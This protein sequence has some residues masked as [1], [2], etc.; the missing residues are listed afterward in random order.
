VAGWFSLIVLSFA[1]I[2]NDNTAYLLNAEILEFFFGCLIAYVVIKQR[3]SPA[4]GGL[5]L[6]LG[7]AALIAAWACTYLDWFSVKE[8][9]RLLTFGIPYSLIIC[10]TAIIE[11]AK[12]PKLL[13]SHIGKG[14]IY[15]GDAS[16]S[17]YLV[18]YWIL[19]MAT[20]KLKAKVGDDF[21]LFLLISVVAAGLGI[22]GYRYI[23][24][25]LLAI[26]KKTILP[27][28]KAPGT[29]AT[30]E[31]RFISALPP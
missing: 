23:E 21:A 8:Y 14:L 5:I 4:T 11:T 12:P 18:H 1:G 19:T 31:A 6:S 22:L 25:P 16:Y 27:N 17:V 9:H 7:L 29:S 24:T 13:N 26:L 20:M 15:M 3:Y 10:G 30:K 2:L 28:K